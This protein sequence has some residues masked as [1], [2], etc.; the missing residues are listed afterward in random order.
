MNI[1]IL[2]VLNLF[3]IGTLIGILLER[4]IIKGGWSRKTRK[5]LQEQEDTIKLKQSK[6]LK[7]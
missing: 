1:S 4:N 7:K 6:G 3:L 5:R 2:G